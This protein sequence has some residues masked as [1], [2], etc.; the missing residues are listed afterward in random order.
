VVCFITSLALT[1]YGLLS[2]TLCNISPIVINV[3][4]IKMSPITIGTIYTSPIN[5][6]WV[7]FIDVK[8]A[9]YSYK[10]KLNISRP[11]Y[12]ATLSLIRLS[13][14]PELIKHLAL[15]S[16]IYALTFRHYL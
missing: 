11:C 9:P 16:P 2:I 6:D 10:G 3:I 7:P 1:N 12:R 13:S 15:L 4:D 8:C 5:L 14:A